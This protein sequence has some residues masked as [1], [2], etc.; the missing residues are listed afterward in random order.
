MY[1]TFDGIAK[2]YLLIQFYDGVNIK[3]KETV[4]YEIKNLM[5]PM[6][7]NFSYCIQIRLHK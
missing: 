6:T 7:G 2:K 5:G 3:L 4:Y 1:K